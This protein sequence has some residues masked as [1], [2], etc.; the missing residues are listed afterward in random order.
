MGFK[1]YLEQ[2]IISAVPPDGIHFQG[3]LRGLR[4][5]GLDLSDKTLKRYLDHLARSGYL[6]TRRVRERG[7]P[8]PKKVFFR[9]KSGSRTP[10]SAL[11]K[12]ET[13]VLAQAT[14]AILADRYRNLIKRIVLFGS[15]SRGEDRP[16]SDIDLFIVS[17][18]GVD[19]YKLT[20]SLYRDINPL[21]FDLGH[22]LSLHVF[23]EDHVKKLRESGSRFIEEVL[24]RGV[25]LFKRD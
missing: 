19:W 17:E 14:S 24:N 4:A 2:R 21:I 15:V 10:Y 3:L 13:Q 1:R 16:H 12:T 8:I 6:R 18:A 23:P 11:G 20:K 22:F 9:T 25:E 7:I 5:S